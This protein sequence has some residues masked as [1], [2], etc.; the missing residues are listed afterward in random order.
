MSVE[1]GLGI[2]A[3]VGAGLSDDTRT[4]ATAFNALGDTKVHMLSLSSTGINLTV[5]VDENQ[6]T[7]AMQRLHAAFFS[8]QA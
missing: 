2:V 6:V 4:V 8:E 1:R 7:T 3:V 5:I